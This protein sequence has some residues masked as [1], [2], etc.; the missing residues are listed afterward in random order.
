MAGTAPVA[1][2]AGTTAATGAAPTAA[3]GVADAAGAA[4]AAGSCNYGSYSVKNVVEPLEQEESVIS[5]N[6]STSLSA[7]INGKKTVG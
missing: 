2:A 3:D 5:G 7:D 6:L 4:L 1:G